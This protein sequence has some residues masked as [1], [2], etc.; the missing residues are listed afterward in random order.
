MLGLTLYRRGL[1]AAI[2]PLDWSQ[3]LDNI[4]YIGLNRR[5]LT[6]LAPL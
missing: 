5:L 2:S 6:V 3:L 4:T 1:L